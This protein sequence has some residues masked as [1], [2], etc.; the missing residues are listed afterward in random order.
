[1]KRTIH[2]TPRC[3]L[4]H[5]GHLRT[6]HGKRSAAVCSKRLS[7]RWPGQIVDCPHWPGDDVPL[8]ASN[9]NALNS[10]QD[11]GWSQSSPQKQHLKHDTS[12]SKKLSKWQLY[13]NCETTP[14]LKPESWRRRV[15]LLLRGWK[16]F[17]HPL[18]RSF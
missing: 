5:L 16:I 10:N 2:M 7:P 14:A 6:E 18:L 3:Y 13:S 8:G 4:F 15:M 9:P 12:P 11:R 1:M 17:G